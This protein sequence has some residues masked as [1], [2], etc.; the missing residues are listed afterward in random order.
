MAY[1]RQLSH[2]CEKY[3][4]IR[5]S[6]DT[7]LIKCCIIGDISFTRWCCKFD[8]EVNKCN[9]YNES[10]LKNGSENGHT[11][12]VKMLFD[13]GADCNIYSD[14]SPVMKACMRGHTE[15]V[16]FLLDNR[17]DCDDNDK[18][19]DCNTCDRF[20]EYPLTYACIGGHTEIV[21]MLLDGWSPL[22]N[23][24]K[25]VHTEIV[26]LLIDKGT[27]CNKYDWTQQSP[28][29]YAC[30]HGHAEI[31]QI[32]L[33]DNRYDL[34]CQSHLINACI[35]LLYKNSKVVVRQSGRL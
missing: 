2:T 17:A 14:C 24:C 21:Q 16:E 33:D 26:R 18:G 7:V 31:V 13:K 3:S 29:F 9:N 30:T 27:D 15:I 12:I 20:D 1:Q 25:H 35:K 19:V 22:L 10:P 8:E 23:A 28:L 34:N 4:G 5:N 6:G 11:E 32:F